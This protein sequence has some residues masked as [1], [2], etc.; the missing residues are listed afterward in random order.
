[1]KYIVNT[2][3]KSSIY[4]LA[5]K[6]KGNIVHKNETLVIVNY[7]DKNSLQNIVEEI[8]G[9]NNFRITEKDT[10]DYLPEITKKINNLIN[11]GELSR[12]LSGSRTVV[13][14]NRMPK[15]HEP[16]VNELKW[17]LNEWLDSL[18]P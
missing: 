4:E 1:M 15:K 7:K 5:Y 8:L 3:N 12:I 18:R 2:F 17:K 11:W 14:Q 16:K 6:L 9:T 10:I 13:S